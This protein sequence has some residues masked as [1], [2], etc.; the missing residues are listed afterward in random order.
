MGGRA[1]QKMIESYLT[2][3]ASL[4]AVVA[5]VDVRRGVEE[6][7]RQLIEFLALPRPVSERRP[8]EIVLVATKIDKLSASA[9]KPAVER[10]KQAALAGGIQGAKLIGFSAVTGAG[11]E[12]LWARIRAAVL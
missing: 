12:D 3:R 4:R 1:G 10:V 2:H 8:L 6:E 11:R 9:R 7:E 5:L